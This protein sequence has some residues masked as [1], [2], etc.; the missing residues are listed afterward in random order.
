MKQLPESSEDLS[1]IFAPDPAK[2]KV[3]AEK[4]LAGEN[5]FPI[6]AGVYFERRVQ[7]KNRREKE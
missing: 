7:E 4:L 6:P 2:V 5:L 3:L 1:R